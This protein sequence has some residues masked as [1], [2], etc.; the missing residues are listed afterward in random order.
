MDISYEEFSKII[1]D[2]IKDHALKVLDM[3]PNSFEKTYA[4]IFNKA[5]YMD[6]MKDCYQNMSSLHDFVNGVRLG[7]VLDVLLT[8]TRM[9]EYILNELDGD[10][11]HGST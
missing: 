5:I 2:T 10:D 9:S 1:K 3:D 7:C 11:S 8:A 6:F 4:D